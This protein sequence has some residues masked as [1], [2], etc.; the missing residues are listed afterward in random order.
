MATRRNE[1]W[2]AERNEQPRA[3]DLFADAVVPQLVDAVVDRLDLTDLV[4]ERVDLA[5]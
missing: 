5:P 2:H 4:L 3:A 1:T